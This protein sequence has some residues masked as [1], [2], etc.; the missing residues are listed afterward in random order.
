MTSKLAIKFMMLLSVVLLAATSC[1]KDKDEI[2]YKNITIYQTQTKSIV[3]DLDGTVGFEWERGDNLYSY[4]VTKTKPGGFKLATTDNTANTAF[5]GKI[6]CDK[7]D[8]FVIVYPHNVVTTV[9]NVNVIDISSQKGTLESIGETAWVKVGKGK[10]TEA[11]RRHETAEG[12]LYNPMTNI[13]GLAKISF[14]LDGKSVNNLERVH[15]TNIHSTASIDFKEGGNDAPKVL[16]AN[17]TGAI[18]CEEPNKETIYVSLFPGK[19]TANF[20]VKAGGV[21]YEGS[22]NEFSIENNKVTE[23][24]VDLA[25]IPSS[26]YVVVAGVKWAPANLIYENNTFKIADKEAV[27]FAA[28]N[29]KDKD[30]FNWG[31]CGTKLA[32]SSVDFLEIGEQYNI[33]GKFYKTSTGDSRSYNMVDAKYGDIVYWATQGKYRLPSYNE[34]YAIAAKVEEK[35]HNVGGIKREWLTI[36][37][38]S[39]YKIT[40]ESNGNSIFLPAAGVR[41]RAGSKKDVG[42]VGKYFTG[43]S[44]GSASAYVL[45]FDKD[46]FYLTGDPLG[47]D[48]ITTL[49]VLGGSIR[50]VL[51]E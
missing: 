13:L 48:Y 21:L 23:L 51:A 18:D 3:S 7:K 2:K 19:E 8:E 38:V 49:K 1:D 30:V 33:E 37:G 27:A 14:T 15:I 25:P 29:T 46:D 22:S 35:D 36:D 11:S 39:G 32:N 43:R 47:N 24:V 41:E 4:N 26:D 10:V 17:T 44:T 12:Y 9:D 20:F 50:P 31:V 42:T 40:D 5:T 34:L 28:T 6:D 16:P 45:Y